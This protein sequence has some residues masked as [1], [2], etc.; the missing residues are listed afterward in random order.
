ME[1]TNYMQSLLNDTYA[2]AAVIAIQTGTI[3]GAWEQALR[4][5]LR[6]EVKNK[7]SEAEVILQ[8]CGGNYFAAAELIKTSNVPAP[9][10]DTDRLN[11][12]YDLHKDS[13][14]GLFHS[15]LWEIII[16]KSMR[17]L[18]CCFTTYCNEKG[19][20][21]AIV[22]AGQKGIIPCPCYFKTHA[23]KDAAILADELNEEVF[24][25]TSDKAYEILEVTTW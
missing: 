4:N 24:G 8:Y 18:Q 1:R 7:V 9:K 16:K 21:L 20:Q 2:N 25:L 14:D 5:R 12:T 17:D 10:A 13:F 3:N 15:T 23:Y 6:Q 11:T 22:I 19:I